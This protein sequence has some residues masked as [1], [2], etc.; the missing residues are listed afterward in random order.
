M[1]VFVGLFFKAKLHSLLLCTLVR[2]RHSVLRGVG[3][4]L[5]LRFLL[6][7]IACCK[8][9]VRVVKGGQTDGEE[10]IKGPDSLDESTVPSMEG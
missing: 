1:R 5:I 6:Y 4:L 8:V 2:V 10:E 7:Q 3:S 9:Q